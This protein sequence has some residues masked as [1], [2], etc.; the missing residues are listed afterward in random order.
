L[1]SQ[2][3]TLSSPRAPLAL[4]ERT[5]R[6]DQPQV[7]GIVNATPDSFSDGGQFG[8]AAA[9]ASAGADMAAEGAAIIDIGGESTRPGARP[10]W[11]GDEIERIAPVIRQLA[12]GGAAVSADTRKSEVMSAALEAG[13]RMINDVSALTYDERSAGVIAAAGVPVILMHHQG[14]PETMQD[15]PRY[16]DVLVEVYLWLEERIA[17]AA[18]AGIA[19]ERVLIDPG[20]GFGKNVGHNLELMNGLALFHSLGAA[21][22]VGASRKRTI[23]AISGEAPAGSRLGGSIAFAL[24]AAE[25]GAQ[26]LRVH[27]VFETV[28]ALKVWRGLR[29]QALTPRA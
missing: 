7:M 12:A 16:D 14:A 22:V 18:A 6:L 21:L 9:A 2:G 13:A 1:G 15:D 28:Q 26:L 3:L 20:F 24:K 5:V 23:G 19:R 4:G 29:D 8:D 11:E 25:Q 10:V 27:D 17:A